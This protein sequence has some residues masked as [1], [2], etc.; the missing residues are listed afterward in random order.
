[1]DNHE[2]LKILVDTGD[3]AVIEVTITLGRYR[4]YRRPLD[5]QRNLKL[6][7][8]L[9]DKIAKL[10]DAVK[11]GREMFGELDTSKISKED[12]KFRE[13]YCRDPEFSA[14]VDTLASHVISDRIS[15]ED[16]KGAIKL[17]N[18]SS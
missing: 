7:A 11:T 1:M 9:E 3:I 2:A 5:H 17:E 16:L 15:M 13:R 18:I 14:F 10:E 12:S 4:N 8:E 6:E